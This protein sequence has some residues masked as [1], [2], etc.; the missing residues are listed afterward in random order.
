MAAVPVGSDP[1]VADGWRPDQSV[2]GNALR[3]CPTV[4]PSQGRRDLPC[5]S[6]L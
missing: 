1:G 6:F 3:D 2:F 5:A 4:L